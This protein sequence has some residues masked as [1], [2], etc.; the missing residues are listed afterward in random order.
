LDLRANFLA[1]VR[2]GGSWAHSWLHS[3]CCACAFSGSTTTPRQCDSTRSCT[4]SI[5]AH[6]SLW[7]ASWV[8]RQSAHWN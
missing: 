2:S 1:R 6:W 4:H 5:R 8:G 3:G 7:L